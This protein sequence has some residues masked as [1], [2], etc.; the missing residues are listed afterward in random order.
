MSQKKDQKD[1]RNSATRKRGTPTHQ[2]TRRNY[3]Y[4]TMM[5]PSSA[6]VRQARL[7]LGLNDQRSTLT[8]SQIQQAFVR[9]AQKFHPDRRH[10]HDATP[11]AKRFQQS[12]EAK[13]VLLFHYCGSRRTTG[14]HPYYQQANGYAK[15]Y[16]F[17]TRNLRIL[18]LKQ[19]LI[20]RG[21]ILTTITFGTL[22]DE[23]NRKK[24]NASISGMDI[25]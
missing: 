5:G 14:V 19:N 4:C 12:L 18:S 10:N 17:P 3:G 11:C 22:Y 24:R 23:W 13:E 16:G 1:E 21:I 7:L 20:L 9:S 15:G 2:H 25:T 8:K 6:S